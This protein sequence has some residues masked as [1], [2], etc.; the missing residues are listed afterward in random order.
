MEKGMVS[1]VGAGCGDPDF[2]TIKAQKRLRGC[3]V[4]IYDSLV[5]E[6]ILEET[7]ADCEKIYVGKRYGRHAMKQEEINAL[8]IG[9]A[10]EGKR[11]VRLKGGDPYVFGRGGEEFLALAEAGIVCEEIPGITSCIAVP[12]AAGIPVTHRGISRSFTVVTGTAAKE[13]GRESVEM[14]FDTLAKLNGTL[15]I[16][17]GMHHLK[18]I[19]LGLMKAGMPSETP[20]AVI[21]EGTTE[22]QR[23]VRAQ[24]SEIAARAEEEKLKSPAV[25][26]VGAA[27]RMELTAPAEKGTELTAPV[28]K[29]MELTAPAETKGL[30]GI[31]VG[32]TGTLHFAEKLSNALREAGALVRDMSFM[33]IR[34]TGQA[35]PD[36]QSYG[37]LV[38][39]SPNGVRIFLEKMKKEKRDLRRLI[40][41]IAVIGTGTA[42]T[43]EDAGIYADY[44]PQSYDAVHLAEGLTERILAEAAQKREEGPAAKPAL[45]LR[46]SNGSEALPRLFREKGLAFTDFPLYEIDVNERKREQAVRH[47]PD[48]VVFGAGSGVRAYFDG[49]AKWGG[50]SGQGQKGLTDD[51]A[52]QNALAQNA[53]RYVCMGEAC[54]GVLAQ[55]AKGSFLTAK[56]SSI[57]GIVECICADVQGV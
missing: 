21:M 36:L 1:L 48:Y 53:P 15:V 20:C 42:K 12:A 43:L 5:S 28:E 11:V 3:D 45:F 9:R 47:K 38:F 24:L 30:S 40:N 8:L 2:L 46:A 16:L 52:G 49:I 57:A 39:T 37:W 56:E 50:A 7:P 34:E 27:A 4:L 35:L 13:D 44:M 18:E 23:C 31:T 14:D 25:I 17:M 54:A 55:Y 26:V 33:E 32:V 51:G 19:A 22:E 41:P 6:R 10:Q 29:R